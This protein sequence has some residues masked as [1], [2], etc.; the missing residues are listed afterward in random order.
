MRLNLLPHLLL[1]VQPRHP[2]FEL[3]L[4]QFLL[5]LLLFC[6]ECCCFRLQLCVQLS[7]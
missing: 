1:L 3:F 2:L 7:S 6:G 5:L 4:A